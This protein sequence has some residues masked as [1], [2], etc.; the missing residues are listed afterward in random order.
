[1]RIPHLSHHTTRKKSA[2]PVLLFTFLFLWAW[3]SLSQSSRCIQ[4]CGM[5]TRNTPNTMT[6]VKASQSFHSSK[7]IVHI[8]T[9]FVLLHSPFS[10]TPV[11]PVQVS[12]R[13]IPWLSCMARHRTQP[14]GQGYVTLLCTSLQG[15]RT[16]ADCWNTLLGRNVEALKSHQRSH[17]NLSWPFKVLQGLEVQQ[18]VMSHQASR[19][20]NCWMLTVWQG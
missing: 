13:H 17:Q 7:C 19:N 14:W 12:A 3:C 18:R 8:P 20:C 4:L 2:L 9:A 15:A 6:P 11:P 10:S 16:T 1:M 5:Q